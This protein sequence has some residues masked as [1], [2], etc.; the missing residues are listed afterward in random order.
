M[1]LSVVIKILVAK[2]GILTTRFLYFKKA[3]GVTITQN[4][5]INN[6]KDDITGNIAKSPTRDMINKQVQANIMIN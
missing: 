3:V 1:L 5:N 4:G 2:L 6:M